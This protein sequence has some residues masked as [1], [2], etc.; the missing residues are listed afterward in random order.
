[1]QPGPIYFIPRKCSIFGVNCEALPHQVNFLTDEAG[2]CG[3]GTNTVISQLDFFFTQ[4]GLGENEVFFH[5]D[6]C[7]GQK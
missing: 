3:K 6:N 2:D 5:A 1:M 4:H 7:C